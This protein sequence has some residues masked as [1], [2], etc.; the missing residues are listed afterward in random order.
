VSDN[1]IGMD[2]ATR[3][4]IFEPFF[5]TKGF[6]YGTGLG[7]ATVYGNVKQM[8]GMIRVESQPGAG[9]TFRIYLP[10]TQQRAV[11]AST[12][13]AL[14]LPRGH[15]SILLVEDDTPV[16]A[17]LVRTLERHGYRVL[18]A[19]HPTT[20]LK[21]VEA[22]EADQGAIDLVI[23]DVV[24]PGLVGPEFVRALTELRGG[25][26]PLPVLY[27]SGY[28]D[29]SPVWRGEVPKASYFLQKPFSAGDLLIRIRQIL[30]P[31]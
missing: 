18:S 12:A 6:G 29:G 25:K 15:E 17:F 24:L 2:D 14:P 11:P 4:R 21:M 10:E 8:G 1:G 26:P 13:P 30:T 16:R 3:Q 28:A 31:A 22:H 23:T 27:I 20:A 7:L 5:T 9:S 19:E